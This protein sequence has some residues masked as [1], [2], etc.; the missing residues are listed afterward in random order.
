MTRRA[1]L[2][3]IRPLP[4]VPTVRPADREGRPALVTAPSDADRRAWAVAAL[5][6]MHRI[7][8]M[9]ERAPRM[10][11]GLI[12]GAALLVAGIGLVAQLGAE[13]AEPVRHELRIPR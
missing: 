12:V 4:V 9:P 11:W 10:P 8:G 6:S 7:G 3:D 13:R 1:V 5:H 2:A